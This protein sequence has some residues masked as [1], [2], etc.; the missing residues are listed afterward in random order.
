MNGRIVCEIERDVELVLHEAC[1]S[2]SLLAWQVQCIRV[3]GSKKKFGEDRR[4]PC[5]REWLYL[6]LVSN[7]SSLDVLQLE[8]AEQRAIIIRHNHYRDT[9]IPWVPVVIVAWTPTAYC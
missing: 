8:E 2:L 3:N 5:T 6:Q 7:F 1:M 9:K 4:H